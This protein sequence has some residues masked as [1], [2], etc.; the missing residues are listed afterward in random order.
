MVGYSVFQPNIKSVSRQTIITIEW[1]GWVCV[2][3]ESKLCVFILLWKLMSELLIRQTWAVLQ[4]SRK[5]NNENELMDFINL[6]F[7]SYSREEYST[8]QY[9]T[10]Q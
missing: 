4:Q 8:V 1:N 5:T 10:V 7:N 2:M 6:T 3:N 9:S